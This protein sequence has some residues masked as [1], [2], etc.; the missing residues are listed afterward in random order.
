MLVQQIRLRTFAEVVAGHDIVETFLRTKLADTREAANTL[1]RHSSLTA[2][3]ELFSDQTRTAQQLLDCNLLTPVCCG[4]QPW[5]TEDE[6]DAATK[7]QL[8]ETFR[9]APTYLYR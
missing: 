5:E 7:K 8:Y 4:F 1:G 9:G 3:F 2:L 6:P